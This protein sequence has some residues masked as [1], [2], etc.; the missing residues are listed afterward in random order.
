[1]GYADPTPAAIRSLSP[2]AAE[3]AVVLISALREVGVPAI[4]LASGAR[5]TGEQQAALV[6]LGRSNA[7]DSAHLR[8]DAFDL[9]VA[10]VDREAIPA[11][12]WRIVGP[13]AERNLGL[14]WGGRWR[15]PYDPGHFEVP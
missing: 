1:M 11:A 13:W 12:F 6:A 3:R 8:G 10:G 15:N 14:R 9:D 4:I 5:R 2:A 7:P